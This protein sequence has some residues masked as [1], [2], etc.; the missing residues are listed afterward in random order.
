VAVNRQ[1]TP[2]ALLPEFGENPNAMF[3][4]WKDHTAIAEADEINR[5][6]RQWNTDYTRYSGG[7]Y[8][9]EWFWAKLLH[10]IRTDHA[11]AANAYSWLEH[12]DW[13]PALLC[14]A[15]DVLAIKRS[16]CAAG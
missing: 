13:I 7:S 4:L 8:S 10:I 2:L 15:N 6:A 3:V 11:V 5:L 1:G 14:G 9:S 12:C 16:R